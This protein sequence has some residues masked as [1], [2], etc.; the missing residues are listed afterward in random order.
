M[1]VGHTAS[2]Y[3]E[4]GKS[5]GQVAMHMK[6]VDDGRDIAMT[7]TY[8]S[9]QRRDSTITKSIRRVPRQRNPF[10]FQSSPYLNPKRAAGKDKRKCTKVYKA[11]KRSKKQVGAASNE[12]KTIPQ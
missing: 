8:M 12:L 7:N 3:I 10:A 2:E 11:R 6:A 1:D 9:S 4:L 5:A